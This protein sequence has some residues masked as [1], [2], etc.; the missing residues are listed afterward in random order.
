MP[1]AV[2][3]LQKFVCR[4]E[5]TRVIVPCYH[6]KRPVFPLFRLGAVK[7]AVSNLDIGVIILSAPQNKV[8]LEFSESAD[9][10]SVVVGKGV[11]MYDILQYGA[12]V[13]SSVCSGCIVE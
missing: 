13:Y 4:H 7:N 1:Y 6:L 5:I 11:V 2:S 12:V 3:F 9:T 10:D 8:T